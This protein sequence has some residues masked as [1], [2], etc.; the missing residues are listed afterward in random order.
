M[1][2]APPLPTAEF[3][4]PLTVDDL[5][6]RD[7]PERWELVNGELVEVA[8]SG[9]WSSWIGGRCY[10]LLLEHG[11][12]RGLGWA[13]P[14]DTG[15][16]LFSDRRT[17][18]APKAAFVRREQGLDPLDPAYISVVPDLVVEVL[19]PSDRPSAALAK[20]AMYL[21][22]GVRIVWLVDPDREAVTVFTADAGPVTLV[23]GAVLDG[24]EVL[25]ELQAPV[26]DL[27]AP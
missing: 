19:S 3:D 11:E 7:L 26:A 16:V 14:A 9:G 17:L 20:V 25:P 1:A 5:A 15:F 21:E 24:G 22:A 8:P 18:R 23:S 12:R 2:S 4:K 6:G 13:F 10:M 27:F